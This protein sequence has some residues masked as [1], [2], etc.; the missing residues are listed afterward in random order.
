MPDPSNA[1]T[2]RWNDDPTRKWRKRRRRLRRRMR[3]GF[4]VLLAV[5]IVVAIAVAVREGTTK[6]KPHKKVPTTVFAAP[7]PPEADVRLTS[8]SYT[9]Y[10]ASSNLTITNHL[11]LEQNYVVTVAFKDG[12]IDFSHAVA[13]IDHLPGRATKKVVASGVST[14][15]P[16]T[17]LTCHVV[18]IKRFG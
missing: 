18:D 12:A 9:N 4:D 8:C 2:A 13:T 10:A 7:S 1:V 3:R 5:L 15:N 17:H 14:L 11:L 6:T 16:P